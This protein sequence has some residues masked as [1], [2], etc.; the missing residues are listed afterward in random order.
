MIASI[1]ERC[2]KQFEL[3]RPRNFVFPVARLIGVTWL[4][5]PKLFEAV[6]ELIQLPIPRKVS[7]LVPSRLLAP[8]T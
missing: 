1:C 2:R 5:N 3:I 4:I 8:K 6:S 7:R